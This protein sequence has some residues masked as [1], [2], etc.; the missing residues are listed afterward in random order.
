MSTGRRFLIVAGI[1]FAISAALAAGA[2]SLRGGPPLVSAAPPAQ[3]DTS[4]TCTA[5]V[6]KTLSA[7]TIRLCEQSAVT[8]DVR[9]MCPGLAIN[10]VFIVDEV[11]K[12]G[13]SNPADRTE[14]LRNAID[15]EEKMSGMDFYGN[16]VQ[17]IVDDNEADYGQHNIRF[18]HNRLLDHFMGLSA[19]PVWG[20]PV[21]VRS[22]HVPR[23]EGD[24]SPK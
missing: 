20:G 2:W 13:Y 18:F 5:V 14:A 15:I 22:A 9:P 6:T 19:Q 8:V 12:I 17:G 16:D 10:I 23:L 7:D 4:N 21:E 11:Y 3:R 24:R 1:A